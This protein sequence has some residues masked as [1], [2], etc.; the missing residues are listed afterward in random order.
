MLG[1]Q[2]QVQQGQQVDTL[3][4]PP[5]DFL[6]PQHALI[7]RQATTKMP[8]LVDL[9]GRDVRVNGAPILGIKVLR[10]NDRIHLGRRQ[11]N[12]WE[13]RIIQLDAQSTYV[14]YTCPLCR[15]LLKPNDE[16]I[17]C[18]HSASALHRRCWFAT[19][20]CPVA[21]CEYPNHTVV[22][23]TLSA[24]HSSSAGNPLPNRP[25]SIRFERNLPES[26]DLITKKVLCNAQRAIDQFPF[27]KGQDVAYC[28]DCQAPYHLSCWLDIPMCLKCGYNIQ[29]RLDSAFRNP[30]IIPA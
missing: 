28:P 8:V 20:L 24:I 3:A 16:V 19:R 13:I 10:H 15:S 11:L 12:F 18:P 26:S 23:D 2:P 21:T 14:D 27:K 30:E 17:V 5:D 1:S 6:Q 25:V 4:L 9:V 7:T 29:A 22:M